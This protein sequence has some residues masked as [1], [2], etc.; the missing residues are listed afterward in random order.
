MMDNL[1]AISQSTYGLAWEV[2]IVPLGPM[3]TLAGRHQLDS[4]MGGWLA[5]YNHVLNWLQP[6]YSTEGLYPLFNQWNISALNDLYLE[7]KA[8]DNAGDEAEL[9]RIND[10]MNTLANEMVMYMVWWHPTLYFVHSSWL[11]GWYFNP[12]LSAE[13]WAPMYYE[14][15]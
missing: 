8:A 10:E 6:T 1:N 9:L 15:P 14:A 13:N 5:D 12:A 7:A 4:Y 2:V 11:Q 3:W